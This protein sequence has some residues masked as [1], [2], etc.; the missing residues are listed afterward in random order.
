MLGTPQLDMQSIGWNGKRGSSQKRPRAEIE[1]EEMESSRGTRA[2]NLLAGVSIQY[3]VLR[4]R[5][6][7]VIQLKNE[8]TITATVL[9]KF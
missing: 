3:K 8:Y 7:L 9:E 4:S 1:V 2:M 6:L 5:M